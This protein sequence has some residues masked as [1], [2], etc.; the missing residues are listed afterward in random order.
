TF[1]AIDLKPEKSAEFYIE[2][3]IDIDVTGGYHDF[4]GFVSGVAGLPRIVTL[5]DFVI[6]YAGSAGSKR[7]G[8]KKANSG[9]NASDAVSEG[10]KGELQMIITA[11]TYR[12]K[13]IEEDGES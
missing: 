11:K 12:Y 10:G 3:P 1:N 7:G 13:K 4:G 6:D 9:P 5:H 2:L 8:K